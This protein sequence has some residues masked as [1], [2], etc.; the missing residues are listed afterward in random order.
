MK[1]KRKKRKPSVPNELP[2]FPG[3]PLQVAPAEIRQAT[4]G[5]VWTEQKARLI[6]RYLRY[7]VFITKHGAYIDGFSAPK[8]VGHPH[9]WAANLV[10]SSE[11]RWLRQFYLCDLPERVPLLEKLAAE[12]PTV[13]KRTVEVFAGDF[14]ERIYDVLRSPLIADKTA[15]FCLL[16]QFSTEC[17]WQTI[18]AIARHKSPKANKIEIFYFLAVGWL[19]RGL[20]AFRDDSPIPAAWWGGPN[21]RSVL[22]LKNQTGM[23]LAFR[24]RFR[25]ELGYRF[26]EAWPIYERDKGAGR[27]MFYMIHA[28]D[29]PEAPKLMGRAY[30]NVVQ[31][32]ESDE[33]LLMELGAIDASS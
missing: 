30:R 6:A 2:L 1:N 24:D 12:Q 18:R 13:P 28:S 7:F 20:T 15:T 5:P 21:W 26:V 27:I 25:A 16:D 4:N 3:L 22:D 32:L 10:L 17:H 19:F 8:Q 31:P 11:P 33:Q 29:H 23:M 9:T 14:N